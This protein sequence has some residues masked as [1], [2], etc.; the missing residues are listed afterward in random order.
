[1]AYF[2]SKWNEARIIMLLIGAKNYTWKK[3]ENPNYRQTQVK[4]LV[5]H[6]K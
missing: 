1:V 3:F 5:A 4:I 6:E 2:S